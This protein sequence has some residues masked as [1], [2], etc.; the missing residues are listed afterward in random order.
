MHKKSALEELDIVM[1]SDGGG[2]KPEST[3]KPRNEIFILS[4]I[5]GFF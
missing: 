2:L 5:F 1:G 4:L 3:W